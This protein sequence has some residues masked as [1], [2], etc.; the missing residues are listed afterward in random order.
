MLSHPALLALALAPAPSPLGGTPEPAFCS[1]RNVETGKRYRPTLETTLSLVRESDAIVR[2]VALD[3]VRSGPLAGVR[4]Y[5]RV[6]LEFEVR[7]VLKGDGVPGTLY[8]PGRLVT[9]DYFRAEPPPY[10][11]DRSLGECKA[12]DYRKGGEFLLMLRRGE[13]GSFSPDWSYLRHTN[14]QIRGADDPW[15]RWVREQ[16]ASRPRPEPLRD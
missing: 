3:T 14:E 9:R 2:A 1:I 12:Y 7:E 15:V 8:A 10:L 13:N 5:D 4:I 6:M 11:W 16:V